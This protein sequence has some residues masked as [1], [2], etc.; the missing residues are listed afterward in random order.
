[1]DYTIYHYEIYKVFNRILDAYK[2]SL[3][4]DSTFYLF[5][6]LNILLEF[7]RSGKKSLFFLDEHDQ[8]IFI[9]K[10]QTN[11]ILQIQSENSSHPFNITMTK[12]FFKKI[13]KHLLS[14][15]KNCQRK[16]NIH[17]QKISEKIF[18]DYE[19]VD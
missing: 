8:I 14:L 4:D 10:L 15:P 16:Y 9:E 19:I 3:S 12:S 11:D 5:G 13:L 18:K 17:D 2:I 6:N 7:T 1:M